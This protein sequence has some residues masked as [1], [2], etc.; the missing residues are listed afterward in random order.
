LVRA[1]RFELSELRI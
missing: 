1:E